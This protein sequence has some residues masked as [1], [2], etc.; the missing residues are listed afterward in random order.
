MSIVPKDGTTRDATP[1]AVQQ[2]VVQLGSAL[3]SLVQ[4]LA[5]TLHPRCIPGLHGSSGDHCHGPGA[6]TNR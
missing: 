3:T 6:A 5:C 4:L 2:Q 1:T